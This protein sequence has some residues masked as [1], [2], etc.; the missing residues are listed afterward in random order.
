[1]M[2]KGYNYDKIKA[3]LEESGIVDGTEEI[4]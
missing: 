4:E 2:R 1:L 3:K